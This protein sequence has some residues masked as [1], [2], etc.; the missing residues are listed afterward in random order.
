MVA[1]KILEQNVMNSFALA[2]GDVKN[3]YAHIKF[4]LGQIDRLKQE[5]SYLSQKIIE[6]TSTPKK[7]IKK[8]VASKNAQKLHSPGCV[9]AKNIKQKNKIIFD[10]KTSG[11]NQG[12][13]LCQCLAY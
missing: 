9:F 10:N 6:L 12:L 8:Y 7:T 4:V 1:N 11:L 5:N 2:K 3:L 13:K